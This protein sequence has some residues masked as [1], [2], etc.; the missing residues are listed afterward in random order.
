MLDLEEKYYLWEKVITEYNKKFTEEDDTTLLIWCNE[1]LLT[2]NIVSKLNEIIN[3]TNNKPDIYIVTDSIVK[4]ED[5]FRYGQYL[6]T[7]RNI[8]CIEDIDRAYDNNIKVI[9]G[10]DI[11]IFSEEYLDI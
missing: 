6:I 5:I 1:Y 4:R 8:K 11:P 10:V 7:N 3:K 9:S 2:E